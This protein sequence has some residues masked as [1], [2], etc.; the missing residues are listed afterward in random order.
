MLISFMKNFCN[1]KKGF[2]AL[3]IFVVRRIYK[4]RQ[5]AYCGYLKSAFFS[6][7]CTNKEAIEQRGTL[8]PGIRNCHYWKPNKKCIYKYLKSRM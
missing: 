3:Q 5:C 8:I 1:N 7:L 4:K 2:T 6:W